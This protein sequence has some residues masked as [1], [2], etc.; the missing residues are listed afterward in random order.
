[1]SKTI[2]IVIAC[3]TD[4]DR[5]YFVPDIPA[6]ELSWRGML[7]GIPQAKERLTRLVDSDN[8]SPCIT[9]LLRA[10]FQVKHFYGAYNYI[11]SA[12]R[13]FLLSL[14]KAG[15]ELGWHPHFWKYDSALKSWSQNY[16]DLNWQ[17]Q[18]LDEAYNSYQE[19][20]PGRGKSVRMGWTYHN[21]RTIGKLDRLGVRVD[22]S[23][24]PG[25]RIDPNQKYSKANYFDWEITPRDSYHPSSLD[26]RR[27]AVGEENSLS[28]LEAPN[29]VSTSM[30]WGFFGAVILAKKMRDFRQV[31]CAFTRRSFMSTITGK[32]F[33]FKPMLT[34]IK[35]DLK[36]LDKVVYVTPLHPDELISNI[37]PVYSLENMEN[38]LR[39]ILKIGQ[40][41]G[42]VVKF[43]RASD[44]LEYV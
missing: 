44:I 33:L 21:N 15:D 4:P 18:M 39:S 3:D 8:N 27:P 40:T 43:I 24:I 30:I 38:N 26:F 5:E 13:E 7:E 10:D 1:M 2:F 17:T 34:Q 41:I 9:W 28:I 25:L 19:I 20:L 36:K 12:H 14:E 16:D 37:H 42:A 35:Q 22:L 23:A 32:P 29:Y 6:D 11:L 31:K